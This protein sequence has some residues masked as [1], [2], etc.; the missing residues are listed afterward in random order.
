MKHDDEFMT[1]LD[2]AAVSFQLVLTKIDA[3]SPEELRILLQN[4]EKTIQSHVA[5]H[6]LP[7]ATSSETKQGIE[8]LQEQL[9]PF[10]IG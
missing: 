1:S 3:I 2:E 9:A 7:I 10:A 6:P 4:I 8:A 5:A